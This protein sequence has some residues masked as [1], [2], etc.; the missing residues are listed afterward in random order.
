MIKYTVGFGVD[1]KLNCSNS[2]SL[3]SCGSCFRLPV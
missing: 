3:L 1:L 2:C